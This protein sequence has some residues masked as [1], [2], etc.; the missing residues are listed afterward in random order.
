[1]PDVPFLK[2]SDVNT[3]FSLFIKI[4]LYPQESGSLC[5]LPGLL[6]PAVLIADSWPNLPPIPAGKFTTFQVISGMKKNKI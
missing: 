3:A 2:P 6:A 5:A 1:L 4:L